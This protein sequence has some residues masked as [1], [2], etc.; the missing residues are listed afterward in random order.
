MDRSRTRACV[1]IVAALLLSGAAARVPLPI[2]EARWLAA[3]DVERE[4]TV[5]PGECLANPAGERE[6]RSVAAGRAAFRSPLLLGGQA[7]RAGLSCA[8]C[9]RNGRG[10][11]HFH[12]PGIS[13][14][15][16]TADVTSSLMSK[17][18]GDGSFNPKPIPDLASEASTLKVSRNPANGELRRFIHGLIVEE[19]DGPEPPEAVLQGVTDYVRALSPSACA[20]SSEPIRLSG[21]LAEVDAA[22]GAAR[23]A[24][25]AGD[26]ATA[27]VMLAAARS[28]LGRID[29]RFQLAGVEPSR[30]M[31][32]DAD[33]ELLRL[34]R[35]QSAQPPAFG[36]WDAGWPARKRQL[37]KAEARSLFSPAVLRRALAGGSP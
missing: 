12:F 21:M 3:D 28:T 18:R 35:Q 9:H 36:R 34:Q 33:S 11:P 26:P 17:R 23:Q 6:R 2:R 29:E 25:A 24:F 7:A 5:Q 22:V 37:L 20:G 32:R 27:R 15:P 14:P 16:G 13:G 1:L 10:N 8:S 30:Q 4:L 31:L 19:F